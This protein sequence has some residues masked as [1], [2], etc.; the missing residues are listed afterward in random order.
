MHGPRFF[1]ATIPGSQPRATKAAVGLR[2]SCSRPRR[3]GPRRPKGISAPLIRFAGRL[4]SWLVPL[5]RT[6]PP[7]RSPGR[8][9]ASCSAPSSSLNVRAPSPRRTSAPGAAAP[10]APLL[11]RLKETKRILDVAHWRLTSAAEHGDVGPAGE[12]LLDNYH[13]VAGAHARSARE[14]AARLLSRTAASS[15][16][17]P[18][19]VSARLRARDHA[20]LAHR[21]THRS[22]ERRRRSSRA[23]QESLAAARSASCG[24]FPPCCGSA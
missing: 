16:R 5:L 13:V 24:R 8:F 4:S 3:W 20:H 21:R 15:R 19:P 23:F 22:R 7:R 6:H 14:L 17:V 10:T 11:A 18:S 1:G 9:A 12:W 2:L